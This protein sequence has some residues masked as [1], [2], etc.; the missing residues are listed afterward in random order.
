MYTRHGSFLKD[1]DQFDP[2]FF[3]IAPR[4]AVSMDPQQRLLLEVAWE[5]LENAV[6]APDKLAGS[7][8]GVY[9]GIS[10]SDY[11]QRAMPS[12]SYDRLNP[13][14]GTGFALSIAAGRL[15]YL[16]GLQGPSLDLDTA[17]C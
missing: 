6:C 13:Y 2:R 9:L 17:C 16:L 3:G 1:V 11:A 15:S 10:A 12:D 8:T 7:R 5:A 14:S 4:E